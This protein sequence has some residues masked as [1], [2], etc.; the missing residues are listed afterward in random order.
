MGQPKSKAN[1]PRISTY[2]AKDKLKG[3]LDQPFPRDPVAGVGRR[4]TLVK[5]AQT[6]WNTCNQFECPKEGSILESFPATG[7]YNQDGEEIDT[8]IV[9]AG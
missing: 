2:R 7:G 6:V 5:I 4:T 3:K 9:P 1:P 8:S